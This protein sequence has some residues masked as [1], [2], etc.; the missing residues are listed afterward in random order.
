M[1]MICRY[2]NVLTGEQ[3]D[4]ICTLDPHEIEIV[5]RARKAD[6][7]EAASFAAAAVAL[8]SAY[9]TDLDPHQWNHLH[10]PAFMN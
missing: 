1:K 4:Q 10:Q 9:T 2:E 7:E 3:R 5:E 6:G 8:R